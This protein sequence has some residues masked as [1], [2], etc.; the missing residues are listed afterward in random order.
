MLFSLF[1]RYVDIIFSLFKRYVDLYITDTALKVSRSLYVS[2]L[3]YVMV[4]KTVSPRCGVRASLMLFL[5]NIL[6]DNDNNM[7]LGPG[8]SSTSPT[9]F[10]SELSSSIK[11]VGGLGLCLCSQALQSL[12]T[13][14]QE[15]VWIP[16]QDIWWQYHITLLSLLYF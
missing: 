4:L 10:P 16:S 7:Y 6:S 9:C 11:Q 1:K 12:M 15:V 13:Q 5:S 3:L 8:G 14:E 2:L